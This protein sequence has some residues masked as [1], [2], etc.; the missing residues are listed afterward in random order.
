[1]V[2]ERERE[3]TNQ[4]TCFCLR[5]KLCG[6]NEVQTSSNTTTIIIN[7]IDSGL[8]DTITTFYKI[9]LTIVKLTYTG[10]L[11][12]GPRVLCVSMSINQHLKGPKTISTHKTH[13]GVRTLLIEWFHPWLEYRK[14]WFDPWWIIPPFDPQCFT[15]I[16][17]LEVRIV[18]ASLLKN[19]ESD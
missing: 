19:T 12:L 14:L 3:I 15:C 1:M 9:R 5:F 6:I 13:R 2:G 10:T 7:K 8:N 16:F 17:V 11:R 4:F 18:W